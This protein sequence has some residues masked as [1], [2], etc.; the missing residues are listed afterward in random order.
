[1]RVAFSSVTTTK[2]GQ[3]AV[4]ALM[5]SCWTQAATSGSKT[6]RVTTVKPQGWLLQAEGDRRAAS[7]QV[8]SFSGSTGRRS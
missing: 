3:S 7:M 4:N 5:P 6:G 8:S 1:M 2:A